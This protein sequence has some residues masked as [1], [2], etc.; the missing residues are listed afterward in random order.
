ME[1]I[2]VMSVQMLILNHKDLQSE[3]FSK[4]NS[5]DE[6]KKSPSNSSL[7][8][9]FDIELCKYCNQNSLFF[10]VRVN[11][12]KEILFSAN[13]NAKYI[14][15]NDKELILKAQKIADDYL[16][17]AKIILEITKEEEL[18]W[19]ALNGIDGVIWC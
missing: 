17:D 1:N 2:F 7:I 14:F 16:Y 3:T 13:L 4:I 12:I 8:F 5:I 15:I 9:D 19:S 18:E 10:G 11:S 6:I